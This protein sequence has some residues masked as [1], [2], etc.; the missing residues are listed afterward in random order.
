MS[1]TFATCWRSRA[2]RAADIRWPVIIGTSFARRTV[3]PKRSTAAI[4]PPALNKE[5]THSTSP[6]DLTQKD[7][8][9]SAT[10]P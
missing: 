8:H 7:R 4:V 3:V 2:L 9:F 10:G 1:L 6:S 5:R